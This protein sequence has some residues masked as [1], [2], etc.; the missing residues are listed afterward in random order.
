MSGAAVSW[1]IRE[2]TTG[3]DIAC[4]YD[5][6]GSDTYTSNSTGSQMAGSGFRAHAAAFDVA[7]GFAATHNFRRFRSEADFAGAPLTQA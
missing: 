6:S 1:A 7:Y 2:A 5:S 4:L 3:T